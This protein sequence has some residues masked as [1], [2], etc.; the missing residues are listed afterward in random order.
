MSDLS[1]VKI[2]LNLHWLIQIIMYVTIIT[3]AYYTIHSSIRELE[4]LTEDMEARYTM[5]VED[6]DTRLGK[7]EAARTADL[8]QNNQRLLDKLFKKNGK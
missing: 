2:T 3:G 5:L 8:E 4:L 6:L 1:K 7:V